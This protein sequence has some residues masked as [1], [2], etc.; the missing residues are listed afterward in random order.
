MVKLP[1]AASARGVPRFVLDR[2]EVAERRVPPLPVIEHLDVLEDVGPR[3]DPRRVPPAQHQLGRERAEEA[4]DRGLVITGAA[5]SRSRRR[6]PP[7]AA[8]SARS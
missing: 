5:P 2:A 3:F 1:V 7:Q 8:A 6:R 4:L